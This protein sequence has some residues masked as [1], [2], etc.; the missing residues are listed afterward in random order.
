MSIS[1]LN[2]WRVN[3]LQIPVNRI[4][5]GN[6]PLDSLYIFYKLSSRNIGTLGGKSYEIKFI[7]F[8]FSSIL[9]QKI[10]IEQWI[11]S[12][13][14]LREPYTIT[15]RNHCRHTAF[16][17]TLLTRLKTKEPGISRVKVR[18]LCC[19]HVRSLNCSYLDLYTC[20]GSLSCCNVVFGIRLLVKDKKKQLC[21]LPWKHVIS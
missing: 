10:N 16:P 21:K 4:S 2:K 19:R 7:D 11:K 20:S 15:C 6:L 9:Y 13:F 12:Q 3:D 8:I 1:Y 18:G 17:I 5:I 14:I